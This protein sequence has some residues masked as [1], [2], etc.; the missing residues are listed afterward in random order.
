MTSEQIINSLRAE[1][2]SL[3]REAHYLED[4]KEYDSAQS[5]RQTADRLNRVALELEVAGMPECEG[6][7]FM[8]SAQ[9]EDRK[10]VTA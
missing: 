5:L 8:P 10:A 1:R 3:L 4:R 6:E 7:G 9:A 2:R